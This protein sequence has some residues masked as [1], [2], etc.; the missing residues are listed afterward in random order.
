M[1]ARAAGYSDVN[2]EIQLSNQ[3]NIHKRSLYYVS[4]LYEEQL[5]EGEKNYRKLTKVI[6]VNFC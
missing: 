6:G 2:V 1:R 3:K 5:D 4:K